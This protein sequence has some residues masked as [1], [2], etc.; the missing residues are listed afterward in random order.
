MDPLEQA[1]RVDILAEQNHASLLRHQGRIPGALVDDQPTHLRVWT[2]LASGFF[3]AVA[4]A[5]WSESVAPLAARAIVNDLSARRQP[6]RWYVGSAAGSEEMGRLLK[7][8]GLMSVPAQTP[9]L[10]ALD[11]RTLVRIVARVAPVPGLAVTQ[12]RDAAGMRAWVAARAASNRWGE[13]VASAWMTAHQGLGFAE[14]EPL[15]HLVGHLDGKPA[16]TATVFLDTDGTAGIY[17]IEVVP[18]LRGRGIASWMTAAAISLAADHGAERAVLTSTQMALGVY[19]RLGFTAQGSFTYFI[20]PA[21]G[22]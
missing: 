18:E 14:A 8:V 19:R 21:L 5:R 10:L 7:A 17:H 9:M 1:P 6:W 15:Q 12:V 20:D 4:R 2:G 22:A 13:R 3:N 16:G 11:D